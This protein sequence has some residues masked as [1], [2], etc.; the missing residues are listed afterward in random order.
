MRKLY[1]ELSRTDK[2]SLSIINLFVLC[3]S[4]DF[5]GWYKLWLGADAYQYSFYIKYF[6]EGQ[7][8]IGYE[9]GVHY[10]WFL[11]L[12]IKPLWL[13]AVTGYFNFWDAWAYHLGTL[14]GNTILFLILANVIYF[15][16]KKIFDKTEVVFLASLNFLLLTPIYYSRLLIKPDLLTILLFT[17]FIFVLIEEKVFLVNNSKTYIIFGIF[18]GF[19]FSTKFTISIVSIFILLIYLATHN[20]HNYSYK[21][22]ILFFLIAF[23]FAGL[24]IAHSES[25]TERYIWDTPRAEPLYGSAPLEY[26]TNFSP[27]QTF[28]NPLRDNL[29]NSFLSIWLVD[30]YGD[31]WEVY[32][33]SKHSALDLL[34]TQKLF[35]ARLC[36]ILSAV[37]NFVYI[38]SLIYKFKRRLIKNYDGVLFSIAFLIGPFSLIIIETL[39]GWFKAS[40]G[41]PT[42]T[43]YFGFLFIFFIISI[44]SFL[45]SKWERTKYYTIIF[46]IILILTRLPF[47]F[48][49]SL[50]ISETLQVIRDPLSS[51]IETVIPYFDQRCIYTESEAKYILETKNSND[52]NTY[53]VLIEYKDF[54]NECSG[55]VFGSN[56]LGGENLDKDKPIILFVSK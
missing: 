11:S 47:L 9:Q 45:D 14:F 4:Y 8:S 34:E 27:T 13:G 36:F 25:I 44:F 23:I 54:T 39:L 24:L 20:R 32:F 52:K 49:N 41:D 55:K 51:P 21:K 5:L 6:I 31:Y 10:F 16:F 28:E 18:F 35:W 43:T 33:L 7:A 40:E 26:F 1:S 15:L 50:S 56:Y 46:T 22:I 38:F 17:I 12:L 30:Y 19:M 53:E 42:K 37:A 29:K 3:S 48:A 2:L